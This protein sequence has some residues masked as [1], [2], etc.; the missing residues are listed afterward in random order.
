MPLTPY[1]STLLS[2]SESQLLKAWIVK[3]GNKQEE[4]NDET[5]STTEGVLLV[6]GLFS[7]CMLPFI[8]GALSFA[9]AWL[10]NLEVVG[11]YRPWLLAATIVT[12]SFAWRRI[13]RPVPTCKPGDSCAVPH[14]R[15]AHKISF[16]PAAISLIHIFGYPYIAKY[17]Y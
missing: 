7:C 16:W 8:L 17:I 9:G 6:L 5:A 11:T 10:S 12:L 2:L 15:V 1:L 3:Q 4:D 13:Y 14:S